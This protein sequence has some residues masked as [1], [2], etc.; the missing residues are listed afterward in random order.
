MPY[1]GGDGFIPIGC[2][3]FTKI[4]R[5][6]IKRKISQVYRINLRGVSYLAWKMFPLRTPDDFIFS[7][8]K[9]ILQSF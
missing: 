2:L 6:T 1:I 7:Y 3:E 4:E 8:Q 5:K 9:M